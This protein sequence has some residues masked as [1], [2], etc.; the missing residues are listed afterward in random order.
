MVAPIEEG[1]GGLVSAAFDPEQHTLSRVTWRAEA[2]QITFRY[3][4]YRRVDKHLILP[5]HA[6]V[7]RDG[8]LVEEVSVESLDLDQPLDATLFDA[9]K[10][11]G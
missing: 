4:D 10:E 1:K 3:D 9:P 6:R 11:S 5:F 8:Q 2:G 7:E